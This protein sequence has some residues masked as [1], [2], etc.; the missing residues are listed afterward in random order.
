MK[1]T[2]QTDKFSD[3]E[4]KYLPVL[5]DKVLVTESQTMT[6]RAGQKRTFSFDNFIQNFKNSDTKNF[7]IEYAGNPA[8]FAVQALPSV[9]EPT[10]EN[11]IDYLTAYYANTLA[12]YIANAN[13]QLKATFDKWKNVDK[14]ALLSNLEKNQELKNMLLEETPWV[15]EAKNETQ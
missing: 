1:I 4:Q 8:W 2:A 10:S 15:L 6:L 13:P 7:T 12:G 11:A 3:G 9:A 14:N 5:P